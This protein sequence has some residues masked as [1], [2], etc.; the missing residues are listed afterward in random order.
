MRKKLISIIMTALLLFGMIE[1]LAIGVVA[2]AADASAQAAQTKNVALNAQVTASGQCNSSESGKFAV[3]GKTDTKWCDNTSAAIKWLKLDLGKVYQ[4]NE[5]KVMNAAINESANAPFWNTKD[6][7]LQKSD[8]GATWTDVDV[9]K[10]NAQSIVDRYLPAPVAARYLRLYVS[11]GAAD[12]NIVRLYELEVYGVDADQIPAYPATNLLPVEYVNPFI[13]TMGDNGQTNPGPSTPFGLVSLGPDSDGGAFSGYYY[14]DK[15]LKGF[16][17]LRFSGVGCSGAGGNILM[18][19]ETRAFTK[20]S[21]DYKQMYVKSSEQASPGYYAVNL[22]SGIGV[23]LTASDN[24]GFHRYTFPNSNTGSVL[25]DLSNSYAGMLDA[26]LKV[27]SGSEISGMIKSKNVCG[28]GYYTMYYSIQFDHNFDSYTSWQGDATGTEAE[29]TGSN[30]GVWVNFNTAENKVVQAKVGLSAVSVEQAKYERDHDIANWDFAA[31]QAKIRNTWSELLGKVEV[32]DANE[33]NKRV[34]YT[35]LYHTFLHPKNVT[36]SLGTFKAGRDEN[37]I[38]Q[39]SELGADF[40]YY[41]GWTTWDDFRKYALFSVLEPKKYN[42]MVK[43]LV[44]LYKTR[45]SYTQ[46]GDGYWPSPTVRN[47]FNG[48]VILDAYAKG[49]KDFDVHKALQGMAVDA[50]NFS[51]SDTEISGKLE[52]AKSGYF[53]MKLAEMIGDRATY[54]KYKPMALSYKNLWNPN[55]VDENGN[56]FGFFTPNAMMVDKADVTKVDKYAYQGNL[57]S[58][59]WSASQDVNGLA[60]L[61]GGK[62]AMAE[63]LQ[64]FFKRNEYVAINEEDLD[65]PYLFN[66]LGMPY[67]TQYYA[68]QYTTEVVTQKYH[69]H[70]LYAYPLK[71]R[72]YRDDPEGYLQSMDDDAGAMSSWFVYSAL[73]LFPGNP[74]DANFLIGSPIFSE[75]KLHLDGGKTLTIKANQASSENRFIQSATLNGLNFD[76]AWIRY[77]DLMAGGTLNF[78]MGPEPN[79]K[80]GASAK[81]APPTT[82]YSTTIDNTI[83]RQT[84]VA[85]GSD[86]KYYDKGQYAGDGWNTAAYDDS[87]WASGPAMLGYDNSNK[88]KTKVSFGPDANNKYPTTYFRKS[89]EVADLK[90]VI[91]LDASLIRDDGAVVYVNGHEVIRTN[92]PEGSIAYDTYANATVGDER[93]RNVYQIDPSYLVQGMNLLSVEVHQVNATSSDIAFDFSL[94]MVKQLT[95]PDAPL[96]PAVDD[97]ANTFGW[98]YVPGFE[99]AADYEFSVDSG[100]SWRAATLNPQTVG[101]AA[102]EAGRVQ[103]RV[104]ADANQGRAAGDALISDKAYTSDIQWDVYD[105]KA[106]VKRTGNM[107]VDVTGTLKGDYGDSAVAVIQLMNSNGQL[108][109]SSSV[110]VQT[111]S[112]EFP[113]TFNVN[114]SK[115]QVN[116]YLV[117]AFN[118]N[119]YDSLWLAEPIVSLPEPK[120]DPVPEEPG[121][122]GEPE[123]DPL[124]VPEPEP[125][126]PDE[127]VEPGPPV[128]AVKTIEF[129][130]RSSWSTANNTFNSKPLHTENG[131][132]GTVVANTFTGAFLSYADVDFGTEGMNRMTVEYTAPSDKAPADAKLE[133]RL[134]AVDGEL[135][136]TIALPNTGTGWGPYK[137]TEAYFDKTVTGKQNLFIVMKGS[138][139]TGHPYIG[140]FDKLTWSYQKNRSDYAKVELE[141]YDTWSTDVNPFN[142]DPLKTETSGSRIQVANTFNGAWLAY[143]GM[144]FGSTGVDQFSIEYAG[145][146]GNTASNSTVQVRLGGVDGP[147]VGT[148]AV[149]PTGDGWGTYK[150]ATGQLTQTLTGVQDIYLVLTGTVDATYKYIG[151]FDNASF[152]LRTAEPEPE[153]KVTVELENRT[154]WSTE[155]NTFNSKP[156]KTEP[157]NGGT[158]VGGTFTGAWLT[159]QDV[160]FGTQGKNYAE[161]VYDAPTNKSPADIVA[162]IRLNDK[163]GSLIGTFNLP[164]TGSGWGTYK[165]A[166]ARLNSALNG[167]QTICI[168]LK[169][170][171]TSSLQYV[172]NLDKMMFS[173][174]N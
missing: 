14:Q 148:I 112:F 115:F 155:V 164:N 166:G 149:P 23:E 30:S 102:Y 57:W 77:S 31:Q 64:E 171:T 69:N 117:D 107:V 24:V 129:E 67:L 29:R 42:N 5:W 169:G 45:G 93:N 41:N 43:S 167:T 87:S 83:S 19:P 34:F 150:T 144:N 51:I 105:L 97:K 27:E 68:R 10:D 86:W 25:V 170:S 56:K 82:D 46:W 80:W 122:P 114:A 91:E 95:R 39:A 119:I 8:D 138:T 146:K 40:Q 22:A 137:T 160:D 98:T 18:M 1:S 9:V 49:F 139:D 35:Q 11:K 121:E 66:F 73:G 154:A 7:R 173:K 90:D 6:F 162:E 81:A 104:K 113:Q 163:D 153:S 118:G 132:G 15:Y 106:D 158:T 71:S 63:Q 32:T 135:V 96:N 168:V 99:K 108:L 130:S 110:P 13:N 145:N 54:E 72:V 174:V 120:P 21:N 3:D 47:E 52:K 88:V 33:M 124:P 59:R 165:T 4:I 94:E 134:G 75:V 65:A 61:M 76:Q 12:S 172:G 26:S 103:V 141:S 92:M 17:H 161:F 48:A 128:E 100:K 79:T 127:P 101:P 157:N 147:L 28:N 131:N 36:S 142:K 38:R 74:G 85:E 58:Y 44:D 55:Q 111:G 53:P 125:N 126:V 140:N 143:K 116:V 84:I 109:V 20:N 133:I 156:L 78:E 123:P 60:Q 37:T 2:A 136:G 152:S 50:D 89:F 16:S 159:Y 70:G 62:R 151:N